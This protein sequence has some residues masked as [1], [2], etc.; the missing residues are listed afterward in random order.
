MQAASEI[1]SGFPA[2]ALDRREIRNLALRQVADLEA[3]HGQHLGGL[4]PGHLERVEIEDPR[5]RREQLGAGVGFR[6]GAEPEGVQDG[7][8][9]HQQ[10][11]V[12]SLD[13]LV[14][15]GKPIRLQRLGDH[16]PVVDRPA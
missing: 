6:V 11:A 15:L 2:P 4:T 13:G 3:H 16:D 1:A 7:G 9:I 10:V 8:E 12:E 14:K 5:Q